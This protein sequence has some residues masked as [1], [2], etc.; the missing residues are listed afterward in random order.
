MG[1]EMCIRDSSETIGNH[2]EI[3]RR[4]ADLDSGDGLFCSV[5]VSEVVNLSE[6][7]RALVAVDTIEKI[8]TDLAGPT[9]DS[10]GIC[11]VHPDRRM[12]MPGRGMIWPALAID[13]VAKRQWNER[14][15]KKFFECGRSGKRRAAVIESPLTMSEQ[16]SSCLLYTSPSPRD[17]L[18][19]RMPS[20]A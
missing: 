13:P 3:S 16:E 9:L 4:V 2:I 20:S 11:E 14:V 17:G 1:S 7:L 18:L 5:P 12:I 15:D 8:V 10:H 6:P 19:S